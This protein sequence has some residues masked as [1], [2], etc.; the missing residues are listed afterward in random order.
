M[1]QYLYYH[2]KHKGFYISEDKE[3]YGDN[4]KFIGE[5]SEVVTAYKDRGKSPYNNSVTT[6]RK[7]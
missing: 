1:K 4:V 3:D 2:E 7:C 5:V 6:K